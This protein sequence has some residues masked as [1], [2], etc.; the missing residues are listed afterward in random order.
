MNN[1]TG[2]AR[3]STALT[4]ASTM[5]F[6]SSS[7]ATTLPVPKLYGVFMPTC[8][9]AQRELCGAQHRLGR[10]QKPGGRNGHRQLAKIS[11]R[12]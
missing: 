12:H 3:N 9:P 7:A 2:C 4:P 8:T 10:Q 6:R 11:P 1:S 5:S